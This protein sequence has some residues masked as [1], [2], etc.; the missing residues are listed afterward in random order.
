M[1]RTIPYILMGGVGLAICGWLMR[2]AAMR[3]P[4][5]V[6]A[7]TPAVDRWQE[8]IRVDTQADYTSEAAAQKHVDQKLRLEEIRHKPWRR[9]N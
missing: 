7:R 2:R 3:A 5:A 4:A 9:R 8:E 6:P 1:K